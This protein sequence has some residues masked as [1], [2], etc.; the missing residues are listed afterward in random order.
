MV[1]IAA[2]AAA[3]AAAGALVGAGVAYG[4]L[5]GRVDAQS[6][7]IDLLQAEL[8]REVARLDAAKASAELVRQIER[9]I[10]GRFDRLE[11]MLQRLLAR[12]FNDTDPG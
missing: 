10:I 8:A 5:K 11:T 6:G 7:R 12:R 4:L 2:A 9:E 3:A 1:A